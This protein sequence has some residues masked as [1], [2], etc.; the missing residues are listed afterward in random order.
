[1]TNLVQMS[2]NACVLRGNV[3]K[4]MYTGALINGMEVTNYRVPVEFKYLPHQ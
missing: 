2:L 4:S 3:N 1:M